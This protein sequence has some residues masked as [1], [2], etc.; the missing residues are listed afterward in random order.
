[1][2]GSK[3][4]LVPLTGAVGVVVAIV[5]FLIMGETPSATDDSAQKIVDFYVD[6]KGTV[7]VSA[8]LGAIAAT[9]VVF[10]FGY[11][12]KLLRAAEGEGG[13][14]SLVMFGG[15]IVFAAGIGIDGSILF[16][17][18]E[19]ADD[20]EPGSV[21]ALQALYDSDFVT[22]AIGVQLMMLAGGIAVVKNAGV[23]P[24]WMGWVAIL[25]GVIAVTPIGFVS[26]IGFMLWTLIASVL[27]TLR[28]RAA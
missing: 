18:A 24:A 1:M 15:A 20:L 9:L 12:R 16:T 22:F 4:W 26:F 6:N 17:L 11:L 27:L 3:A 7:F 21:H 5:S 23:L 10:F 28:G 25:L 13:T 14:L 8:A 2:D 19:T